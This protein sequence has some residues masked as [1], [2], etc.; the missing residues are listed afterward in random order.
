M[1]N[2]SDKVIYD[3]DILLEG[4]L[5]DDNSNVLLSK[6]I[7][8]SSELG[9]HKTSELRA[10]ESGILEKMQNSKSG[11]KQRLTPGAHIRFAIVF[12]DSK[13]LKNATKYATRIYS[14]EM[15]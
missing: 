3:D 7:K 10:L 13:K 2:D 5:F 4:I 15:K 12:T 14:V 6:Q 11:K 8:A 9:L 1:L